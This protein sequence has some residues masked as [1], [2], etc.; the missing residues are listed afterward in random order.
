MN[1]IADYGNLFL[2]DCPEL[3]V[4]DT[5]NCADE[6][7]VYSVETVVELGSNLYN[8]YIKDVN[9]NKTEFVR[10]TIPKNSLPLYT[11]SRDNSQ[12]SS[13]KHLSS[14]PL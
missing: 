12:K 14:S 6:S 13:Q 9:K 3:V 2:Y 4:F 5:H 1:T 10:D 11:C 8:K 7:V